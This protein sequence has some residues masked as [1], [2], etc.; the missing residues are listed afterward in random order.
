MF[1]TITEHTDF[2]VVDKNAGINFHDEGDLGSGLFSLVKKQLQR[3]NVDAELFPVHRLDKMTSGLVIFAKNLTCA[4]VFG[5]LFNDHD[6]E[7]YYLAIS[8]KKPSKKQGLIKGDMA[9]SR[10]GMF[11]LLRTME[12]PAITQFFSFSIANKQRLYLLKPHSGKTHQLR[13]ALAS[14]GA[15]IVG[16]PLYYSQSIADRGYLHA[17][18]LKFSYLGEEFEFTSLPTKGKYYLNEALIEQL[19]AIK[20]PWQL[21]WPRL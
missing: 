19:A 4:Q 13:V 14:I 11:K 6:I 5:K 7:K 18:S 10:R 8:D 21:N 20:K 16:D 3:H 12:N 15:P 1:K 9:K 2:I 17:Y